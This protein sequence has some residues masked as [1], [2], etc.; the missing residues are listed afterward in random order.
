MTTPEILDGQWSP[1]DGHVNDRRS[2]TRLECRCANPG[3][4]EC[5]CED[6]G[7]SAAEP[8]GAVRR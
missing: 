5:R 6:D 1:A 8:D 4:G 7:S 2:R 3:R